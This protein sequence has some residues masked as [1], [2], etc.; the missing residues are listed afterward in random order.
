MQPARPADDSMALQLQAPCRR[1]HCSQLL[2]PRQPVRTVRCMDRH[3]TG[4]DKERKM[5]SGYTARVCLPL[6]AFL[7]RSYASYRG[8]RPSSGKVNS[9]GFSRQTLNSS[10]RASAAASAG[11]Q[12]GSRCQQLPGRQLLLLHRPSDHSQCPPLAGDLPCCW[13]WQ[14]HADVRLQVAAN[15]SSPLVMPCSQPKSASPSDSMHS[16]DPSL[17]CQTSSAVSLALSKGLV[18]QLESGEAIDS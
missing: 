12:R 17:A 15:Q 6:Q 14:Q 7:A 10:G 5:S 8:L 4:T 3:V 11:A 2:A 1:W 18:K 13:H 16:T 9:P